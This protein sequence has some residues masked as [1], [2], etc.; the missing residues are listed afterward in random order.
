MRT[1]GKGDWMTNRI[2]TWR[3]AGLLVLLAGGLA[4]AQTAGPAATAQAAPPGALPLRLLYRHFLA[5]QNHLDRAAAAHDQE[6]KDGS[7][8]RNHYQHELGF[9]D[10]QFTAI[11]QTAL[12]LESELKEQD[13]QAKAVIDAAHAQQAR[14]PGSPADVPPELVELQKGRDSL[15]DQEVALLRTELGLEAAGR[16]DTYLQR[17]FTSNLKVR[18]VPPP[19]PHGMLRF[20]ASTSAKGV[21]Q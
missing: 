10:A 9:T 7:W 14:T 20:S 21:Q 6:G 8:L 17:N 2:E 12:R 3:R 11:R 18:T 16:L 4:F 1:T 5:V 19:P 13:A 15:I